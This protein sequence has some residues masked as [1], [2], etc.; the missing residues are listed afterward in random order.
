MSWNEKEKEEKKILSMEKDIMGIDKERSD[1][2]PLPKRNTV[3]G[4][5]KYIKKK[6]ERIYR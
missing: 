6:R 5:N 4:N 2:D 1:D 3:I